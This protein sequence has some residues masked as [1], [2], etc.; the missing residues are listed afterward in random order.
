MTGA[1]QLLDQASALLIDFDGPVATLMPPPRNSEA[2]DRA[3]ASVDGSQFSRHVLS[4]TDH[5]AVLRFALRF[6]TDTLTL[7][8]QAC[9][10]AEIEAASTC[11]PSP[12]A[13]DLLSYARDR[14]IPVAIVSNNAEAAVRTF[15]IRMGWEQHIDVYS[16][17]TPASV[18][19]LK[20]NPHL[21]SHSLAALDVLPPAAVFIGD[22]VSDAVAGAALGVPVVGL[23]KDDVRRR[24][25][26]DA[27]AQVVVTKG[28]RPALLS[29]AR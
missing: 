3:R 17:R 25:L 11:E 29:D 16:C 5:L 2:A 20:P 9:T 12:H 19:M 27:G 6:G 1:E 21:L 22:S 8:E 10:A 18:H 13:S 15:L 23:A 26:L 28:D 7:V 14:S 24:E 4:T